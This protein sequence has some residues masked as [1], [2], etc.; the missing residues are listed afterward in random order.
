MSRSLQ[1][2]KKSSKYPFSWWRFVLWITKREITNKHNLN[3]NS[4]CMLWCCRMALYNASD[5]GK[6]SPG[7]YALDTSCRENYSKLSLRPEY[8]KVS[9]NE[10]F[11]KYV[12]TSLGKQKRFLK[13]GR[14]IFSEPY[15]ATN[16][17]RSQDINRK[18]CEFGRETPCKRKC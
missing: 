2:K 12:I 10:I 8:H 1:R 6:N 7:K 13:L 16:R 11:H 15:I 9:S 18:V 3:S 17:K 14:H 4:I 5:C